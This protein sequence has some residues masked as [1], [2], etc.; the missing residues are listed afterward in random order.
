[1]TVTSLHARATATIPAGMV[2]LEARWAERDRMIRRANTLSRLSLGWMT[3]EG[4]IAITAA[5]L[6]SSIALLGVGLDSA[7]EGLAS[8]IVIWRFTG[9]QRLSEQSPAPRAANG[10]GR[11]L[12]ARPVHRP[13]YAAHAHP[14]PIPAPAGSGIGLSIS[15]RGRDVRRML[16]V[17]TVPTALQV[18]EH[19]GLASPQLAK[20]R[21]DRQR[22]RPWVWRR[23][24]LGW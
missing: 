16:S 19:T 24:G 11:L 5:I 23:G 9:N 17:I 2:V 12:P 6:V 8:I 10:R 15:R 3:V 22:A 20:P 13:G 18:S 7:I 1:M 14:E 21:G 4:A